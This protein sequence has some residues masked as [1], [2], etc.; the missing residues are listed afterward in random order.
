MKMLAFKREQWNFRPQNDVG[1]VSSPDAWN[2][3]FFNWTVIYLTSWSVIWWHW[4]LNSLEWKRSH[5]VSSG[6]V[7]TSSTRPTCT[8]WPEGTSDTTSL[9][10]ST[11]STSLQ[12]RMKFTHATTSQ[13]FPFLLKFCC[14]LIF[15]SFFFFFTFPVQTAGGASGLA[16][17]RSC[18][19]S[20]C[21]W[22]RHGPFTLIWHSAV[23]CTPP[24]LSPL[25]KSALHR[26]VKKRSGHWL[27]F[28]SFPSLP[29]RIF[30]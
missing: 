19:S 11:C 5:L 13:F 7:G 23:S 24:S 26:C 20:S 17:R 30:F 28:S 14:M 2:V 4:S 25:I 8:I 22:W 12:V 6:T 16:W 1:V 9:P 27:S 10:T 15:S 18:H 29:E 3:L 21:C